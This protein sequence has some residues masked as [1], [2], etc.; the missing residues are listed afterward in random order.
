MNQIEQLFKV[1]NNTR[2]QIVYS[3]TKRWKHLELVPFKQNVN[4]SLIFYLKRLVF[5]MIF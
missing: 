5:C 2:S 4:V 1:L 3:Q